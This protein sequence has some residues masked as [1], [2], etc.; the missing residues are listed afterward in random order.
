MQY[1]LDFEVEDFVL[2]NTFRNWV[3]HPNYEL[4]SIVQ[5]YLLQF[6]DKKKLVEEA[7]VIVLSLQVQEKM[8]SQQEWD[9]IHRSFEKAIKNPVAAESANRVKLVISWKKA[10]AAAAVI[11]F[12]FA[13]WW[14]YRNHSAGDGPLR[15]I[16]TTAYGQVTRIGL[17]DSSYVTLNANSVLTLSA[18]WNS[19]T[20][21][22]VW[23]EG[24]AFF[25]VTRKAGAPQKDFIV[26]TPKMDIQVLGTRFDVKSMKDV[27]RV[28]L[29]EGKVNIKSPAHL[30]HDIAMLPG[31][32]VELKSKQLVPEKKTVQPQQYDAWKEKKFILNNTS[33]RELADFIEEYYGSEVRFE[34]AALERIKLDGTSLSIEDKS[35]FLA[36]IAQVSGV[37]IIQVGEEII[38]RK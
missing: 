36:I 16:Y 27:T 13:G 38:I 4:E 26:H 17:P 30:H 32:A 23:L 34:T 12:V 28:V 10:F 11:S 5:Q 14:L 1:F 6:P 7:R 8:L 25:E 9:E 18:V 15:R 24:E 20:A 29:A 2:D 19:V 33:L 37:K 31:D 22:E 35:T 3:L 21:R